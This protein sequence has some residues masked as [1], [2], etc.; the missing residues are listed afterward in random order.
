MPFEPIGT[1]VM[2]AAAFV[3]PSAAEVA[4]TVTAPGDPGAVKTA[5]APLAVWAGTI[6]PALTAQSIPADE[7]SLTTLAVRFTL[8]LMVN[9]AGTL[10]KKTLIS[11]LLREQAENDPMRRAAVAPAAR[12][13]SDLFTRPS[14]PLF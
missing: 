5:G 12:R 1:T 4:V 11:A 8:W 14:L 10:T 6:A 7:S 13:P 3:A 9:I 2:V